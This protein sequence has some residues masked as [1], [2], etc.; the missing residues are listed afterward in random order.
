MPRFFYLRL[1]MIAFYEVD[2]QYA[3]YL[4]TYESKVPQI[5]YEGKSKFVCGVVLVVNDCTY[6]A[7]ISS[8]KDRQQ[9][10]IQITDKSGMVLSTIRFAY[11]FPAPI[12][13]LQK[14]DFHKVQETDPRYA[15]LLQKE[16]EFCRAHEA[17]ICEKARKVYEIGCNPDHVL[18]RY[19]CDFRLLEEKRKEYFQQLMDSANI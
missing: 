2:K 17:Q 8:Q 13:I 15:S 5:Q 16:Y 1:H 6:F 18:N 4:R 3:D 12:D 7:P 11:M 14:M 10:N 19:C 9:T